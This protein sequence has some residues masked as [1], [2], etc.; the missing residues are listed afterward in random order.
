MGDDA[1]SAMRK[2]MKIAI[3][4]WVIGSFVRKVRSW[5]I[6]PVMLVTVTCAILF[7]GLFYV[8]T[9]MQLVQIGYQISTVEAKNNELKNRKRE[10][11]LEIASLQSPKELEAKAAKYGLSMPAVGK[12][13]HVP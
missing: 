1:V 12:V 10:L 11:M 3:P 6:S 8:W 5:K 13:V 7:V 2:V 4:I 9:R